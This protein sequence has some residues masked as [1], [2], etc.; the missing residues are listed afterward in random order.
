[1]LDWSLWC[2]KGTE[3]GREKEKI[4]LPRFF[5]FS[6]SRPTI[7]PTLSIFV[8]L[9]TITGCGAGPRI[10]VWQGGG[11][12]RRL[13][14]R[15]A[16]LLRKEKFSPPDT[17]GTNPRKMISSYPSKCRFLTPGQK[18]PTRGLT[19]P[20]RVHGR[21]LSENPSNR[22]T[23]GNT[24]VHRYP[25]ENLLFHSIID[26]RTFPLCKGLIFAHFSALIYFTGSGT[27]RHLS[28]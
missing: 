14:K 20:Q 21:L 2:W 12:S 17:S 1:M 9:C 19:T 27:N 8:L 25:V 15:D 10:C 28:Y 22:H 11:I 24:A 23:G 3:M 5:V 16:G 13:D 26:D 4:I 6:M 7:R 18:A